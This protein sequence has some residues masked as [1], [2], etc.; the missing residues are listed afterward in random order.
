MTDD[1]PLRYTHQAQLSQFRPAAIS[2]VV[3]PLVGSAIAVVRHEDTFLNGV[4]IGLAIWLVEH[5]AT[6]NQPA[7]EPSPM[8]WTRLPIRT[9]GTTPT[10]C[11]SSPTNPMS[12]HG[13]SP[14]D[15]AAMTSGGG[16]QP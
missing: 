4:L 5:A 6:S 8:A 16:S 3:V 7:C 12:V 1:V 10:G 2:F 14:G 15:S 9:F 13:R 11:A